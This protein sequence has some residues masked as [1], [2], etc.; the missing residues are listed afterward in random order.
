M[1]LNQCKCM[2]SDG[3][4]CLHVNE[5]RWFRKPVSLKEK[6]AE[7]F[8]TVVCM[9]LIHFDQIR[10]VLIAD[11]SV[12]IDD[13][14]PGKTC[15]S[16]RCGLK[17]PELFFQLGQ[18]PDIITV[19]ICQIVAGNLFQTDVS[20]ITDMMI[21][22]QMKGFDAWIMIT[23]D[24]IHGGIGGAIVDDDKFQIFICLIQHTFNTIRKIFFAVIS[25][26]KYRN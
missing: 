3:T 21:F 17:K 15:F 5:G 1:G 23:P 7:P 26:Q 13:V 20:R 18:F 16:R 22:I 10:V 24:Q 14:H 25:C 8:F 9:T 19:D 2:I 12:F 6:V 4:G 11:S